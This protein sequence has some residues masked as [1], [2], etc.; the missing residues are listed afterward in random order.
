MKI[1][2]TL[3]NVLRRFRKQRAARVIRQ[4]IPATE[5]KVAYAY[6]SYVAGGAATVAREKL[7][8]WA[9]VEDSETG[10]TNVVGVTDNGRLCDES[11]PLLGY[12]HED[13]HR[14]KWTHDDVEQTWN[15]FVKS[16]RPNNK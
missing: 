3:K 8:A 7:I 13:E 9:I 4:I 16:A 12:V 5:W 1:T 2:V 6:P 10:R 15:S 14:Q 11:R